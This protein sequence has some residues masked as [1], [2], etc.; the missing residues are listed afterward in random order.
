MEVFLGLLSLC[1]ELLRLAIQLLTY[2]LLA[3]STINLIIVMQLLVLFTQRWVSGWL[4]R[5]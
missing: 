1:S 5:N 3:T 4:L 2:I